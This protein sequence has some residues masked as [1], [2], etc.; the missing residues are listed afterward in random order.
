[1]NGRV[2]KFT[3]YASKVDSLLNKMRISPLVK[4]LTK[5]NKKRKKLLLKNQQFVR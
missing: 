3:V 5:K 4:N 2:M 1:M